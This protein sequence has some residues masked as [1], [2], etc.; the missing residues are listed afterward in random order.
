[1][2]TLHKE[3]VL[4]RYF[5]THRTSKGKFPDKHF[6]WGILRTV[7]AELTKAMVEEVIHSQVAQQNL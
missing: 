3:T 7:R 1:M 5:D 6:F 4:M 2:Y